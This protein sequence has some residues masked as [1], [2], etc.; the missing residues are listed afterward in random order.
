[1]LHKGISSR[2]AIAASA[3]ALALFTAPLAAQQ[4]TQDTTHKPGGLNAVAQGVSKAG[5]TVGRGVKSGVKHVASG[6]H[7]V[8]KSTGRGVKHDLNV[9]T[10][11]TVPKP[12]SKPGGLNKVARDVSK[13]VKHVG[14]SAKKGVRHAK[15]D[16]HSGLTDAGKDVKESVKDSTKH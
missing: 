5:K 1:M 11:D 8:L 15:S 13:S 16:A 10:G 3:V 14:R 4:G 6:T 7:H 9:A 2:I 12:K